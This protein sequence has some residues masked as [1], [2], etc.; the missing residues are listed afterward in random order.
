MSGFFRVVQIR[1]T[2]LVCSRGWSIQPRVLAI[3]GNEV[4]LF[5]LHGHVYIHIQA[6]AYLNAHDIHTSLYIYIYMYIN[7]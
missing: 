2:H 4:S 6:Y 3:M 1:N 5:N 7:I